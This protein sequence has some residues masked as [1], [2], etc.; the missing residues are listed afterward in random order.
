MEM[1]TV[2]FEYIIRMYMEYPETMSIYHKISKLLLNTMLD[3]SVYR[4]QIS[5]GTGHTSSWNTFRD[6]ER[7][8]KTLLLPFLQLIWNLHQIT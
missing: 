4:K 2:H 5:T 3:V 8:G 7:Y 6:N 1:R